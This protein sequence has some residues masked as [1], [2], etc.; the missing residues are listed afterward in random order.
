MAG[1]G[2]ELQIATPSPAAAQAAAPAQ[3]TAKPLSRLEKLRQQ[4]T[5]A[6]PAP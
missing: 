4:A 6:S 5:S 3:P 2:A 1:G